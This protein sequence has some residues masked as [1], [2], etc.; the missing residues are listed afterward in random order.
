VGEIYVRRD[1]FAVDELIDLLSKKG[2]VGKV[3]GVSEWIYYCDHTR[4]HEITKRLSLHPWYKKP[5]T[6]DFLD[7]VLWKIEEIWKHR[8]EK[9]V[10][11]ALKETKLVPKTPHN[12]NEIMG[13]ANEHFVTEDLHSEISISS[14]VASTA[15]MDDYSGVVNISP[16]A[17]LIGRV[18][19]GLVTPWSRNRKFPVISVE[20][21]GHVLPPNIINNLEIFMLNV[22]RFRNNPD[23]TDLID[24]DENSGGI[25][26]EDETKVSRSTVDN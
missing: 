4:K 13:N 14:G 15:M 2:I 6:R 8:V 21:D 25:D 24:L 7:L 22:M 3:S 5:F 18:I 12:M 26:S 20:I 11:N 19:D 16:F 17:C 1:D 23:I 10:K 9:K